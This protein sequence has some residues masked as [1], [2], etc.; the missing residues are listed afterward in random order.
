MTLEQIS[1]NSFINGVSYWGSLVCAVLVIIA[2]WKIFTKA[3][4]KG[5]KC[6]IPVYNLYILY[7]LTWRPLMFIPV[8][9]LLGF[10]GGSMNYPDAI[11]LVLAGCLAGIVGGVLYII[12]LNQLSKSFG[13]G[14]LFTVG[15][16]LLAP[17][18]YMILGF[19]KAEYIGNT[20]RQ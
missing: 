18:F 14:K 6:L 16:W 19:G 12:G 2:T 7:K 17:I 3:G 13:K 5:W 11:W 9:L 15:L 20:N 4:E 10:F 1:G 8:I